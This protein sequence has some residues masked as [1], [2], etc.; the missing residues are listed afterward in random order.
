VIILDQMLADLL[1]MTSGGFENERDGVLVDVKYPGASTNAVA[2]GQSL[3]HPINGP[4]IGV[5][6]R[7]DT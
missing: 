2:F 4:L 5:E 7:E 3:E 1:T 6:A